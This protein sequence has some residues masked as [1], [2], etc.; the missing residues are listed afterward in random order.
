MA[1]TRRGE[2]EALIGGKS[3][4]MV[5]TL[6]ALAELEEAFAVGDIMALGERFGQGRLSARDIIRVLG[7]GLRG[8]GERI[9]DE[10]LAL[11]EIEGGAAAAA[12]LAVALLN[13][14]FGLNPEEEAGPARG[15]T[16]P[17]PPLPRG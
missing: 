6:G 3:R 9:G 4:R 13:H 17:N 10:E 12:R 8:A 16:S 7:A 14:A 2:I 15:A 1:N 5:L 11:M